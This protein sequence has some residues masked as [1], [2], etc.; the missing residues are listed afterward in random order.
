MVKLDIELDFLWG[1][2]LDDSTMNSSVL[3]YPNSLLAF[4]SYFLPFLHYL[5]CASVGVGVSVGVRCRSILHT[6]FS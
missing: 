6:R 5:T 3:H 2:G 1:I 4:F